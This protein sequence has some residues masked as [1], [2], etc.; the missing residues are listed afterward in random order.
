M[1]RKIVCEDVCSQKMVDIA[2]IDRNGWY[3]KLS[4]PSQ[5]LLLWFGE[6][7][8]GEIRIRK[9][10]LFAPTEALF[11]IWLKDHDNHDTV[12]LYEWL[13]EEY[14]SRYKVL[15]PCAPADFE[16]ADKKINTE[17]FENSKIF[18]G[19]YRRELYGYKLINKDFLI[20]GKL[21]DTDEN[22][23]ESWSFVYSKSVNV[24]GLKGI[25]G[26]RRISLNDFDLQHALSLLSF[27]PHL[28]EML[29]AGHS[30]AQCRLLQEIIV[31]SIPS[32]NN[33][34]D[35]DICLARDD[36]AVYKLYE[37]ILCP[38]TFMN[39]FLT[40]NA[41]SYYSLADANDVPLS[42]SGHIF[43]YATY[44]EAYDVMVSHYIRESAKNK[45]YWRIKKTNVSF[46]DGHQYVS[47]MP[48]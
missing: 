19:K 18:D 38:G 21:L 22:G 17:G 11:D 42:M 45:R 34:A 48:A 35:I 3:R 46:I 8:E 43:R 37:K 1:K 12:G 16:K 33:I 10:D 25:F 13:E 31:D 9:R 26:I 6:K 29:D 7:K 20:Y 47:V 14:P 4:V 23:I 40:G 32:G 36:D 24:H 41:Y 5:L 39:K 2:V 27:Y 44:E 15:L 30:M 28:V